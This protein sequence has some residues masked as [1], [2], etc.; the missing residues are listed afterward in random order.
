MMIKQ[1]DYFVLL[2]TALLLC[3]HSHCLVYNRTT[4]VST[5]IESMQSYLSQIPAISTSCSVRLR[6][7]SSACSFY[8]FDRHEFQLFKESKGQAGNALIR[9][10]NIEPN[11]VT[12]LLIMNDKG[13]H[14]FQNRFHGS[15]YVVVRNTGDRV[16]QVTGNL[17]HVIIVPDYIIWLVAVGLFFLFGVCVTMVLSVY[18]VYM[19]YQTKKAER[20]NENL[21]SLSK[22]NTFYY[23]TSSSD[24]TSINGSDSPTEETP[25]AEYSRKYVIK[26]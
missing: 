26:V 5:D 11:T 18:A 7:T 10:E 22:S 13:R 24:D 19:Y 9:R 25:T 16:T 14:T 17:S 15:L 3:C 21:L 8:L 4:S 2:L 23:G 1:H 6:C 12:T 20:A